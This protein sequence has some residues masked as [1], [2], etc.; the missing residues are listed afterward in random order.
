MNTKIK[1]KKLLNKSITI[2]FACFSLLICKTY[3][4]SINSSDLVWDMWKLTV[5]Q[6][7]LNSYRLHAAEQN[8]N[9]LEST[10]VKNITE[11]I[12][13]YQSTSFANYSNFE[14]AWEGLKDGFIDWWKSYN[15]SFRDATGYLGEDANGNAY[16]SL[17]SY[18]NG[19]VT[20]NNIIAKAIMDWKNWDSHPKGNEL[21]QAVL[22]CIQELN[23]ETK[24][25]EEVKNVGY[26]VYNSM[27]T[28]TYQVPYTNGKYSS[29]SIKDTFKSN[30]KSNFNKITI[31]QQ[32]FILNTTNCSIYI[33][34]YPNCT[35][36][37]DAQVSS[38]PNYVDVNITGYYRD[39]L[40]ISNL[41]ELGL[42]RN[43]AK[44]ISNSI[45]EQVI[46]K[47]LETSSTGTSD[48]DS[49]KKL[50]VTLTK[51]LLAEY[52]SAYANAFWNGKNDK[53]GV[54]GTRND[55]EKILNNTLSKTANVQYANF[56]YGCNSADGLWFRH[57]SAFYFPFKSNDTNII[58]LNYA[59]RIDYI[60]M[61]S[62]EIDAMKS[63]LCFPLYCEMTFDVGKGPQYISWLTS[64]IIVK[65]ELNH[66]EYWAQNLSNE[67]DS[68]YY[69]EPVQIT[70]SD[71]KD[72][73]LTSNE[74]TLAPT[75]HWGTILFTRYKY[76]DY[77]YY[78]Y[79]PLLHNDSTNYMSIKVAKNSPAW[80]SLKGL[81]IGSNVP[82]APQISY[83][84]YLQNTQ[85]FIWVHAWT[86]KNAGG[87]LGC[88]YWISDQ[89]VQSAVSVVQDH[90]AAEKPETMGGGPVSIIWGG[91]PNYSSSWWS[92]NN[93][94]LRVV[95]G[96]SG[97]GD[98][99]RYDQPVR[100]EVTYYRV[101]LPNNANSPNYELCLGENA[102]C[103]QNNGC[104][105]SGTL[106]SCEDEWGGEEGCELMNSDFN[107]SSTLTH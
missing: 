58:G 19:N 41:Q 90:L 105:D 68:V 22:D 76:V 63:K 6:Q 2:F 9:N 89:Q 11:V 39:Y 45:Y 69:R 102:P 4:N 21:D 67:N 83:T 74:L 86:N 23:I 33:G 60:K 78:M 91:Q 16:C 20:D 8:V 100:A 61:E 94:P 55:I 64:S 29:S 13:E 84:G 103:K 47:A 54:K 98:Y 77:T 32:E 65:N 72:P 80:A 31:N 99:Y 34:N 88:D 97:Y 104:F 107:I 35:L 56:K 38:N 27:R 25:K 73:N 53:G 96:I 3:A 79:Y 51:Y 95:N 52:Q 57:R 106:C 75:K 12:Q 46:I 40:Q 62:S 82:N 92:H 18:P 48:S 37:F 28:Q 24:V 81:T 17:K 50:R 10:K 59:D 30:I 66:Y 71:E 43:K 85:E 7:M 1:I 87:Q 26:N 42:T 70:L 36:T 14:T 93:K 15:Q 101:M 49:F 5:E 44:S